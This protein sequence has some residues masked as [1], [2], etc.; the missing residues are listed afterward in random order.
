MCKIPAPSHHEQRR[1]EFVCKW[2][3][4]QGFP[5]YIDEALN[6]ICP[7]GV[8]DEN[9][10]IA[11]MAHTDTVFPDLS[12]MPFEETAR[13]FRCPGV[14][15]DTAH[16]AVMMICARYFMKNYP[17]P[18][19]GMLFIANSCEEGLG[20]LK[21]SRQIVKQ[22]GSRMQALITLDG[23]STL[24]RVVNEA[25]GSH[26]Y[27]VRIKTEGGHSF[28]AFGNRNAI[29]VLSQMIGDLYAI[30]VPQKENSKTTFNVGTIEGGTSVNTIAQE[31]QMLYEYRSDDRACL[32]K[33]KELFYAVVEDYR[34][35]G[36]D[37][38][39]EL[40]GDR[41]CTGD[42][43]PGQQRAL[44][45]L[46]NASILRVTGVPADFAS[47][48]TDCN[49]ALAEG[50]PS[51]C[52]SACLGGKCHTR[53]EYLDLTSLEPGVCLTMDVLSGLIN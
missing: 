7:W 39:V 50:I 19:R 29:H 35:R 43:D 49:A 22:Y 11:V 6:V 30:E 9:D 21:G 3:R 52:V 36:F 41:P 4:D 33:M 14:T 15:D 38:A 27:R 44:E 26:R 16:L 23:G 10:V 1:A 47:G 25:V 18:A 24:Q 53:E 42:V 46:V 40:I 37:V 17:A 12:P 51:V 45:A 5:A 8:T 28:N 2:F 34:S 32:A 48:S 31:A 13:Y 20:N